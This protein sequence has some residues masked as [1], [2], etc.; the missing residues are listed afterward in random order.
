M[1]HAGSPSRIARTPPKTVATGR[2]F[3]NDSPYVVYYTGDARPLKYNRW[4]RARAVH[5]TLLS[6][7]AVSLAACHG[8]AGTVSLRA[9][10]RPNILLITIDTFRADRLRP[11]VTPNLSALAASG[12]TFTAARSAVPLTLPSHTTILTGLLPPAHGV[13][14]NG[15]DV[16]D[17]AHPTVARLLKAEGYR[18]AA[19][20]GAFVLDRRFGLARG[21]DV[22]DDRI[23]RDPNATERL[24]AERPAA[25]VIDAAVAWLGHGSGPDGATEAGPF[26]LWIHLYDPHAPYVSHGPQDGRDRTAAQRYDGEVSY[27]D[28]QIARVFGRLRD[29][30]LAATTLVIVAGDHGEG[31]GDHGENTHG[32]LLY[33]STLRVPLVVAGPA[34]RSQRRD[35][36]V[37]LADIAPTILR[38]VGAAA[39]AA[40]HGRDLLNAPQGK[41]VR[42]ATD[43]AAFDVYAETEYPRV[44]GWAALQALTDGRWKAIRSGRTVE[45]Y[46]LQND[47]HELRDVAA[48]QQTL[49]GVMS[50]RMQTLHS[51]SAARQTPTVSAEAQE[52]LRALGYVASSTQP[53]PSDTAANPASAIRDWNA[54]EEQLSAVGANAASALPGLS[55]LAARYPDAPVFQTTY[56]RALR[57]AG[58]ASDALAVYRRA[59][60]RW[61]TD[62]VLLHDLAVAARD[63]ANRERGAAAQALR[64]E[65]VDADRAAVALAPSSATARN[66]LGL[67]AVDQNQP[68]EAIGEFAK[69]TELDPNNASYWVNLGNARRAAGDAAGAEREFRRALDVDARAVDAANGLG[70]LL[71][72]AHRPGEAVRWFQGAVAAAP[73]F[74]EARLNLGIALQQSG[75][76]ARAAEAYRA[77][78]AAPGNHPR[79]KD[80]ARNLL[81]ALES[82]R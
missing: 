66:G 65:A 53:A 81:A 37:S 17:E 42:R 52:R 47:A 29:T 26:F 80:A 15:I 78:L 35:D 67:L 3:T 30:A 8:E 55:A 1:N 56:A 82:G 58:R 18:T 60:R 21:F 31:L 23:P 2:Y 43:D 46:D 12:A 6:L 20:V 25:A 41:V 50:G 76:S 70:V 45:I 49:A 4:M 19:F 62:A 13:R 39:P 33:D 71:V 7:V 5:A 32:M 22:Y 73:D 48:T 51:A 57:E 16:L 24:E 36:P 28:S 54:F 68:A 74:M 27:V 79:E 11:D 61:P 72:E 44:A 9:P 14:E 34:V 77:V 59:A 64:K 75:E 40:M 69:A 38:A 63:A 10:G